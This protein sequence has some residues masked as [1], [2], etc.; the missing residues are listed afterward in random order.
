MVGSMTVLVGLVLVR[1]GY[2]RADSIAALL[3]AGLVLFSAG[4]LMRRNVQVLMDSAPSRATQEA[5]RAAIEG[6]AE[7]MSLRRLRMREVGGRYFAD[8]VVGVPSGA[9]VVQG[10]AVASAIEEAIERVL[11]DSD[12]VVHVEPDTGLG[13]GR[14]LPSSSAVGPS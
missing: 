6:I 10:H 3:V 9:D 13:A 5:A 7:P 1:A 11:P 8:V 12:V 2:P 14:D 4:R